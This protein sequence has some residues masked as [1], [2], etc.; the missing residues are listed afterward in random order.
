[1]DE[2]YEQPLLLTGLVIGVLVLLG[3]IGHEL[4]FYGKDILASG[5]E[6]CINAFW[7]GADG[8]V[9][10]LAAGI[11]PEAASI[12]LVSCVT[13]PVTIVG[14]YT[15]F[16]KN[17]EKPKALIVAMSL[18][19]DPLFIDFF[20]DEIGKDDPLKKMFLDAFGIVTFLSASY[21]W[22]R[23]GTEVKSGRR[24][25]R[26]SIIFTRAAAILLFLLPTLAISGYLFAEVNGDW[27]GFLHGLTPEKMVGFMG[28]IAV[29]GVGISLSRFFEG[30]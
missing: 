9:A 19:L 13:I 3:Y 16:R 20:K 22:S 6:P 29:A 7:K 30:P 12:T 21:F 24:R 17:A 4:F 14:T 25:S 26:T 1:M 5:L 18:F 15:I 28:L 23:S 27:N 2:W 10:T 11:G 8:F